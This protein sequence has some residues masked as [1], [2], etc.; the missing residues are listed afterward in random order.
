MISGDSMIIESFMINVRAPLWFRQAATALRLCHQSSK[1]SNA[2]LISM[3]V[4]IMFYHVL[5]IMFY[6]V[7]SCSIMFYHVL[8]CSMILIYT[9]VSTTVHSQ[10][11]A[12]Y[13]PG[14]LVTYWRN[15]FLIS[16]LAPN[17]TACGASDSRTQLHL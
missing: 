14:V 10:F 7:L 15:M 5:Y 17:Q 16:H 4:S 2:S 13:H 11:D 3:I 6:H 9:H 12:C 1:V 8:S